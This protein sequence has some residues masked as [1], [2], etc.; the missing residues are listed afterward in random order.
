MHDLGIQQRK[1]TRCAQTIERYDIYDGTITIIEFSFVKCERELLKQLTSHMLTASWP[2]ND[3]T[4]KFSVAK[5]KSG[6]R[7]RSSE[8]S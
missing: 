8:S 5:V 7:L 3:L 1:L 2:M 4:G 6:M